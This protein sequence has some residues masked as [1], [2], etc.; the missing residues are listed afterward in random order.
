MAH[1]NEY[2]QNFLSPGKTKRE[3]GKTELET[4][5]EWE[6]R[7]ENPKGLL[8][9]VRII[10][11]DFF[12]FFSFLYKKKGAEILFFKFPIHQTGERESFLE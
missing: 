12:F 6:D 7:K 5:K 11:T 2:F 10:S 9:S 4:S 8:N 3:K 1:I